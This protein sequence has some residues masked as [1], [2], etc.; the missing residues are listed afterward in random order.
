MWIKD[1]YLKKFGR[2][3]FKKFEFKPGLNTVI[4]DNESGK[5]TI[6][7]AIDTIYNGFTPANSNFKYIPWNDVSAEL[8]ANI[9][10]ED[11]EYKIER[12]LAKSATARLY[13][14]NNITNLKN[15]PLDKVIMEEGFSEE[16][17]DRRFWYFDY[18]ELSKKLD[19]GKWDTW[20]N[21]ASSLYLDKDEFALSDV[22][23]AINDRINQIYTNNINSK[24]EIRKLE[25]SLDELHVKHTNLL[26]RKA[27]LE[28]VYDDL[29]ESMH[30]KARI[31]AQ[32]E[33]LNSNQMHLR[34]LSEYKTKIKELEN[35]R[36]QYKE[37]LVESKIDYKYIEAY[38][39]AQR[40]NAQMQKLIDDKIAQK[41][42]ILD[43][44]KKVNDEILS[45]CKQKNKMVFRE[46]DQVSNNLR[47][48]NKEMF[49]MSSDNSVDS[50]L[51]ELNAQKELLED[52]VNESNFKISMLF[53]AMLGAFAIFVI[54]ALLKMLVF[55]KIDLLPGV[56]GLIST[57]VMAVAFVGAIVCLV[58]WIKKK[59]SITEKEK[60]ILRLN[61]E[62][63]RNN[64]KADFQQ[65]MYK[66]E[67]MVKLFGKNYSSSGF[68]NEDL[69]DKLSKLEELNNRYKREF[70]VYKIE[71]PESDTLPY[72]YK[73][74]E[75]HLDRVIRDEDYSRLL[76]SSFIIEV[77]NNGA[78]IELSR[79]S[80]RDL[81]EKMERIN[82]E[83]ANLEAQKEQ[84]SDAL[85]TAANILVQIYNSEDIEYCKREFNNAKGVYERLRINMEVL[86]EFRNKLS[87][88]DPE[89]LDTIGLDIS[90]VRVFE[91]MILGMN[92]EEL[93]TRNNQEIEAKSEVGMVLSKKIGAYE[94]E[95]S[96]VETSSINAYEIE[97]DIITTKLDELK[98]EYSS[99]CF[100][101]ALLLEMKRLSY[102]QHRPAFEVYLNK[103]IDKLFGDNRFDIRVNSANELDVNALNIVEN[104]NIE[105][106]STGTLSQMYF[107]FRLSIM[108]ELD[109]QGH[110]PLI[111]DGAFVHY[112]VHRI[113]IMS[114]ILEEVAKNRQVIVFSTS[115]IIE[116]ENHCIMIS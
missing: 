51:T 111:V 113:K 112:D 9:N 64:S 87:A 25:S 13:H 80:L 89:F 75:A 20:K 58:L 29:N 27:E 105:S 93:I 86:D 97:I 55:F 94:N 7:H 17:L 59:N 73:E 102:E 10:V 35:T 83:I 40:N 81:D 67:I 34:F 38:E 96:S 62:I 18:K 41:N 24:S 79:H 65:K 66:N 78:R 30:S 61:S 101:R 19:I 72:D 39:D 107:L 42:L 92:I 3:K 15:Q 48:L 6:T 54:L 26:M 69:S 12:S 109:P 100:M 114:E 21:L 68:N 22:E 23:N 46:F 43:D 71:D 110:I 47:Q 90:D 103:H 76:S 32:L 82:R 91:D 70:D 104:I 88:L 33:A 11:R 108:D 49:E 77:N 84:R 45:R 85:R 16:L 2:H 99:L 52:T 5:T 50:K 28:K 4:G 31:G 37:N 115:Q 116:C 8:L 63:I 57:V 60:Q 95:L 98:Q 74:F 56:F 14:A 44:V 53:N 36:R 1:I 106:L